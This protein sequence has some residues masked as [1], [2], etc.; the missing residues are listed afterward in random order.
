[1]NKTMPPNSRPSTLS[2]LL[3]IMR[4][5]AIPA[6]R[7]LTRP[8][9]LVQ[10]PRLFREGLAPVERMFIQAHNNREIGRLVRQGAPVTF[11]CSFARSG[12]T[13][14]CYLLSDVLLQNQGIETT[15]EL[16]I[17]PNK[18]ITHYYQEFI[19]RR[20]TFVK[21]PGNMI[22]THDLIP[23]LQEK[24]GGDPGVRRCKY[25]YLFRSPE[26]S[27][28]SMFHLYQ[29]EIYLHS[30]SGSD[31]D[32]FCLE[33]IPGWLEHATS[34]LDALDQGVDVHLVS[35]HQLLRQA[36]FILSDT[37][38]WLGIPHNEAS[39]ARAN[40]N[41]RFENLKNMEAKTLGDRIPFFRR[42]CDGA[43]GLELKPET[44]SKIRDATRHVF[45]RANDR[46]AAQSS[47]A[48]A[49]RIMP[50]DP[51][52]AGASNNGQ[53]KVIVASSGS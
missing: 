7:L 2:P 5:G 34:Y 36:D 33:F 48:Q 29:R 22:K 50:P 8:C 4:E 52:E 19:V 47:R 27:L 14:M 15:T 9:T 12:N 6:L 21:T 31:I 44:L 1:M 51:A 13:W 20:N 10:F 24:I 46:L 41:M 18:I 32:L 28:V 40:S 45:A 35:Y 49:G 25:L 30:K 23:K 42:G 16:P 11:V 3:K 39:V 53:A 37:L 38:R 43:S 17:D 26:E